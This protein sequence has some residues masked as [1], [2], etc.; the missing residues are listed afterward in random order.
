MADPAVDLTRDAARVLGAGWLEPDERLIEAAAVWRLPALDGIPK[1]PWPADQLGARILKTT[2][3]VLLW[4]VGS[5]VVLIVLIV[6]ADGLGGGGGESGSPK[7]KGPAVVLHG[8]GRDSLAGR[9]VTPGLRRR[10][11]WVFTN[12]RVAFVAPRGRV[13]GRFWSGS[14]PEQ[15]FPGPVPVDTV[16][17]VRDSAYTYEGDVDRVRRTRILRRSKP[18]GLYKRVR[19]ADGSGIDFRRRHQ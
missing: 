15:E 6:L 2:G 14:G 18:A 10:G 17:E 8:K 4:I 1:P 7:T 19:F 16:A 13:S 12:R 3:L 11:W 9:L 5:V